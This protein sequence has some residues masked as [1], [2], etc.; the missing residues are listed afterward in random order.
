MTKTAQD[1]SL[2]GKWDNLQDMYLPQATELA[3]KI[4]NQNHLQ[5]EYRNTYNII[6]NL[7]DIHN[8]L[9]VRWE[10]YQEYQ[11]WIVTGEQTKEPT[12]IDEGKKEVS[13]SQALAPGDLVNKCLGDFVEMTLRI[14]SKSQLDKLQKIIGINPDASQAVN[15]LRQIAIHAEEMMEQEALD[16]IF[17]S[18]ENNPAD[19]KQ[20]IQKIVSDKYPDLKPKSKAYRAALLEALVVDFPQRNKNEHPETYP[21]MVFPYFEN[22]P[23]LIQAEMR[24]ITKPFGF[25][26]LSRK[27]FTFVGAG[28][29]LTGILQHIYTGGSKINLVEIDK[30]AAD[31][32]K[33]LIA[34]L[35]EL[36]ITDKGTLTVI[37]ADALDLDYAPRSRIKDGKNLSGTTVATDI[38]DL[39]SALPSATTNIMME[40]ATKV[41]VVRK[42]NTHGASNLL[43]EQYSLSEN[44]EFTKY[45]VVAPPQKVLSMAV[46][47]NII[48]FTSPI[49]VNSCELYINKAL[50]LSGFPQ[51]GR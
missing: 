27:T 9:T 48:G 37:H 25:H 33:K 50:E 2:Y 24:L 32:A 17:K 38:L 10:A 15:N 46:K 30:Q 23:A 43:Y 3:A 6:G 51:V 28:F 49:N 36:N 18:V 4:A 7:C 40:K 31:N 42:R 29:P 41:P 44:L 39:A 20:Q 5:Y 34:I 8:Q 1:I 21:Q 19:Y 35:E 16:V 11:Q 14:Y 47:D 22:Y 45:G 26:G 13:A 12:F